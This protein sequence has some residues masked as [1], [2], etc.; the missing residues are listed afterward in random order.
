M[1]KYDVFIYN[2]YTFEGIEA[3]SEAEVRRIAL[4][5]WFQCIPTVKVY[6]SETGNDIEDEE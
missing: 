3:N 5:R 1:S 2:V 6:K 4:E